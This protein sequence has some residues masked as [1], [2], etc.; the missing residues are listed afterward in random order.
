M[1]LID[2]SVPDEFDLDVQIGPAGGFWAPPQTPGRRFKPTAVRPLGAQAATNQAYT[3]FGTC[4]TCNTNCGTCA[5]LCDQTM[6]TQCG[7]NTCANTCQTCNTQCGQNTCANTCQTC[8]TQCGQN[9]CNTCATACNQHTCADTCG[10]T[11]NTCYT[12][13]AHA[14]TCG[15]RC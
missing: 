10:N 6:I 1:S 15:A 2:G 13:N 12:C 5:V 7:Q 11:C 14:F 3:C 4:N 8:N 9:T